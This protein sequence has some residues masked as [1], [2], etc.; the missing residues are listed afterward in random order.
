MKDTGKEYED[1]G[2][3]VSL[4]V[5][6]QILRRGL[7]PLA[8]QTAA[9]LLLSDIARQAENA[10]DPVSGWSVI[11]TIAEIAHEHYRTMKSLPNE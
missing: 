2:E 4:A 9:M 10:P 5:R 6:L 3:V 7:S 11:Q 1:E 8:L